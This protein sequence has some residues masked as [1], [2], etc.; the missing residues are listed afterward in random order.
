MNTQNN[1][2]EI[3]PGPQ[4]ITV[5]L[6]NYC[7]PI[8][9]AVIDEKRE[10]DDFSLIWS[11]G[12]FEEAL[13]GDG[14]T[15]FKKR[16]H[17]LLKSKS[18]DCQITLVR[19]TH[20]SQ[21][22]SP[23]V[24]I[25]N[26]RAN[27]CLCGGGKYVHARIRADKASEFTMLLKAE[28][29]LTLETDGEI[30]L[31]ASGQQSYKEEFFF[32]IPTLA[33]VLAKLLSLDKRTETHPHGL[34]L[35]SGA[36]KS[37]KSLICRAI[38]AH[39]LNCLV[40]SSKDR[41]FPHIVTYEDP[42]ERWKIGLVKHRGGSLDKDAN[43][44]HEVWKAFSPITAPYFGLNFTCREKD[45]DVL[46]LRQARIDAMRQTPTCFLIGEIREEQD[47]H[48]AIEL[49]G[50]GHLVVATTHAG[51]ISET[52]SRLFRAEGVK[53]A[54]DR[55]YIAQRM[56]G[57]IHLQPS[58]VTLDPVELPEIDYDENFLSPEQKKNAVF[59]RLWINSSQSVSSL[60]AVGLSSIVP[61]NE[62][63][64]SRQ[65]VIERYKNEITRQDQAASDLDPLHK[66][67]GSQDQTPGILDKWIRSAKR[68]V[69]LDD[70][71]HT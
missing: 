59:P 32:H 54:A 31:L 17:G 29:S 68:S 10:V 42:R 71:L 15:W 6:D 63:V 25:D 56:K 66:L 37:S 13:E 35:I 18:L 70:I 16:E 61:N 36:T 9:N 22:G 8:T 44:E 24:L 23:H 51:S 69:A 67:I 21:A 43:A 47:W 48:N 62:D 57:I 39:Y 12:E 30:S 58:P 2:D 60:V 14:L 34:L 1:K 26:A 28:H 11:F 4:K 33:K 27:I 55:G 45:K 19:N 64:I 7:R 5:S 38:V 46:D 20:S 65:G 41:D 40:K 52:F 49:A 3:L 53:T 50:T